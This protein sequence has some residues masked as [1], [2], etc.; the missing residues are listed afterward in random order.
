MKARLT[1]RLKALVLEN[2]NLPHTDGKHT[3][4]HEPR[5][6]SSPVHE[7][8]DTKTKH[9]HRLWTQSIPKGFNQL[10]EEDI[11]AFRIKPME[12]IPVL[13]LK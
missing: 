10:S 12:S 5:A 13:H 9:T 6:A 2:R 11:I 3:A 7:T 1:R 8:K 4:V